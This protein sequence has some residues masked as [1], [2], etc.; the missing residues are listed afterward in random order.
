MPGQTHARTSAGRPG[1]IRMK[2]PPASWFYRFGSSSPRRI[3]GLHEPDRS[4]GNLAEAAGTYAAACARPPGRMDAHGPIVP[5]GNAMST[6][7]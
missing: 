4:P 5:Q 2:E 1:Y 7:G 3:C 6:V